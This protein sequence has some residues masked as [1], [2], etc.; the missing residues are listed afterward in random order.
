VLFGVPV[1][2]FAAWFV[3]EIEPLQSYYLP[4]YRQCCKTA[5]QTA[6]TTEIRWLM[7]T[8][9]GRASQPAIPS[10]VT[11]ER[12]GNLSIRLSPA[13]LHSGW[14]GLERSVPEQVH[15]IELKDT[16]Y[17]YIYG[18]LPYSNL[19]AFPLLESSAMAL[20]I[21]AFIVFT[22]RAE[23]W[24]EW[25]RLWRQVTATDS[26]TDNWWDSP[27]IRH[28]IS[29]RI[30]SRKWLGNI[31]SGLAD[32]VARSRRKLTADK[33]AIQVPSQG[34]SPQGSVSVQPAESSTKLSSEPPA[35]SVPKNPTQSQS[36]FPGAR[37]RNTAQQKPV[38]WGE[39]QWID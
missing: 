19:V 3:W 31:K 5:E 10:D 25:Q 15:S 17:L 6:S 16:L 9:P 14:T 8:A 13:A 37:I 23:L 39:S 34:E 2:A 26:G 33:A 4:A 22:T 18:G 32:W 24:Q 7:K 12:T 20:M 36:I 29:E 21:A 30:V 11:T 1:L 38:D 28:R 27:P 35:Q